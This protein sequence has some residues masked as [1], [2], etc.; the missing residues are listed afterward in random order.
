MCRV[1]GSIGRLCEVCKGTNQH[2]IAFAVCLLVT[3]EHG[4]LPEQDVQLQYCEAPR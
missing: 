2:P 4:P 3:D 1:R